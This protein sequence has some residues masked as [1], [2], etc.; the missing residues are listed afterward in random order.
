MPLS[1]A[2]GASELSFTGQ[3]PT[4]TS[5]LAL[6]SH[7]SNTGSVPASAVIAPPCLSR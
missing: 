1:S 4:R 5:T 2:I 6:L 7:S 3:G